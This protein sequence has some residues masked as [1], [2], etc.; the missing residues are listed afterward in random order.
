MSCLIEH[1][2]DELVVVLSFKREQL[3]YDIENY[4]FI[5]GNVSEAES[6]RIKHE[7]QAAGDDGNVDRVTRV[8][9]LNVAKIRE[10][11][12]PYTKHEIHRKELDDILKEPDVYGVVLKLPTTYSQTTINYMELLIHEYLVCEVMTDWMSFTNLQKVEMWKARSIEAKNSL[13][14][15]MAVRLGRVRRKSHPF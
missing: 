7:I 12:F 15:C 11:L 3:M 14:S 5:E 6:A 13:K 10:L 1:Q 2:N 9:N 4:C 8:L